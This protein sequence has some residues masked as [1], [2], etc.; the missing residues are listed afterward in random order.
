[1]VGR[2]IRTALEKEIDLPVAPVKKPISK[3]PSGASIEKQVADIDAEMQRLF[4]VFRGGKTPWYT[5]ER[6]EKDMEELQ[7]KKADLEQSVSVAIP[8]TSDPWR[9]LN[10][11]QLEGILKSLDQVWTADLVANSMPRANLIRSLELKATVTVNGRMDVIRRRTGEMKRFADRATI[12]VMIPALGYDE[13][14]PIVVDEDEETF[15]RWKKGNPTYKS[16]E[17]GRSMRKNCLLVSPP[18]YN[19]T[20]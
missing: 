16:G 8:K 11:Q 20:Q 5:Y 2:A 12:K 14:N 7:Q 10:K 19:V 3:R 17:Q 9:T 4:Q 18:T 6:F 15:Q 1:M 13:N